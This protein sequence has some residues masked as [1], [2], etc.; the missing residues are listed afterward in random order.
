MKLFKWLSPLSFMSFTYFAYSEPTVVQLTP[1][2]IS[3]Q[4][5]SQ[6]LVCTRPMREGCFN[7]SLQKH[8]QKEKE[9][10]IVNCY[11]M[12][13]SGWTTLFGS[14]NKAIELFEGTIPDK[15]RPI[16]VI[17]SGCMGL[18][19]A[20]EL[21][22]LDYR[23]DG[24]TT[25]EAYDIPSWRAAGYFALVSVKTS[26]QEQAN[27]NEIGMK[28]FLTYRK[29]EQGQHAYIGPEAVRLMPVFCS[30][31][32]ES[33]VEDLEA[34]GLIPQKE[35]VTLDFGNGV[36]HPGYIKY[37]TYFMNTTTLMR[38]LKA[39]VEKLGIPIK[40]ETV[41]SYDDIDESVI[42]NCAG[43][44]GRELNQD[45]HMVPV[46]GHLAVLS[47]AAGTEHMDYMIYTK[48][49]QEGK[50]EYIY[51]FPKNCSVT[52]DQIAGINCAGVLGGTFIPHAD[53]LSEEEQKELDRKEFKK[54]LDRNSLFF[55]G[56]PF[57]E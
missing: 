49:E 21:S 28:T 14:V 31:E 46:R 4:T 56:H 2:S 33:G 26:P 55:L 22:R 32:T 23:V 47:P 10:L 3:R 27:L 41:T 19:A 51:L 42:F 40:I 48:V 24:I 18:T 12:G 43:L 1:P 38:Q 20:I 13:G 16:R 53:Q 9:K 7:I 54:L 57:L 25:K 35:L 50:E 39:E 8:R 52:P 37:M 6:E 29:I 45:A 30:E 11:G 36:M 34:R 44:G 5:V 17:G 15:E